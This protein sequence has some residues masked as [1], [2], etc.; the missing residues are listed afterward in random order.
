M[1]LFV[2]AR[3]KIKKNKNCPKIIQY[4]EKGQKK[5]LND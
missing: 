5:V 1:L 3:L 4:R 2:A